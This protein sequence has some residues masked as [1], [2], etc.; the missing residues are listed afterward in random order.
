M[1]SDNP[2]PL[3]DAE[4]FIAY[5]RDSDQHIDKVVDVQTARRIEK[6]MH[7]LADALGT[8]DCSPDCEECKAFNEAAMKEYRALM[9]TNEKKEGVEG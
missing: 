5:N 3:C 4:A 9:E 7:K 8:P 6:V 2:T 1:P